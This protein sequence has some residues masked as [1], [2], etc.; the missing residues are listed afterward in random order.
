[1]IVMSAIAADFFNQKI[2]LREML[3]FFFSFSLFDSELINNINNY[4][5]FTL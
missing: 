4:I 3:A 5:S 2:L 1:M